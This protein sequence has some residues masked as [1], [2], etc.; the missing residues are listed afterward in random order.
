MARAPQVR[1]T[2]STKRFPDQRKQ[3]PSGELQVHAPALD[4]DRIALQRGG[5]RLAQRLAVAHIELALMQRTLDL[6]AVKEAVAQPGPAVRA[7]VVG[8]VE[9]VPDGMDSDVPVASIPAPVSIDA[10]RHPKRQA[11]SGLAKD[12][13][14]AALVAAQQALLDPHSPTTASRH[15]WS[16]GSHTH[17]NGAKTLGSAAEPAAGKPPL[18]TLENLAFKQHATEPAAGK[19]RHA[20]TGSTYESDTAHSHSQAQAGAW[21]RSVETAGAEALGH[22]GLGLGAAGFGEVGVGARGQTR[23]VKQG[24]LGEAAVLGGAELSAS[25]QG[26]GKVSANRHGV[27]VQAGGQARAGLEAESGVALHTR[28]ADLHLAG[29]H[30]DVTP[31]AEARGRTSLGAEGGGSV[32]AGVSVPTAQER[33][34]GTRFKAEGDTSVGIGGNKIGLTGGLWAGAGAEAKANGS[35]T[36]VNGHTT[37][38]IELQAGAALGLG[39]SL[40]ITAQVDVQPVVDAAR[41]VVKLGEAVAHRLG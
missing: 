8:G 22:K 16:H 12:T 3:P 7:D 15:L 18:S 1:K 17:K 2:P 34:A 10:L 27:N 40:G 37:A 24:H 39:G 20:D 19:T 33:A 35:I 21:A 41:K 14:S 25:A 26:S 4:P 9:R 31:N 36:K 32:F 29:L 6:V 23:F 30:V 5:H 28:E 13:G 11:L 38:R